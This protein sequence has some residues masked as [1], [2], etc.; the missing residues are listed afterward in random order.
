[1]LNYCQKNKAWMMIV[2]SGIMRLFQSTSV[3]DVIK[4]RKLLSWGEGH[5]LVE[6]KKMIAYFDFIKKCDRVENTCEKETSRNAQNEVRRY[7][8]KKWT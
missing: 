7:N 3:R 8:F 2:E 5:I 4:R 1:M 6:V